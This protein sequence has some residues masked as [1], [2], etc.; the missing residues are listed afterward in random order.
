[1]DRLK[2]TRIVAIATTYETQ[3]TQAEFLALIPDVNLTQSLLGD[4]TPLNLDTLAAEIVQSYGTDFGALVSNTGHYI[5]DDLR[6]ILSIINAF[7][8]DVFGKLTLSEYTD[9][10]YCVLDGNRRSV[11]L[12][13]RLR[14]EQTEYQPVTAMFTEIQQSVSEPIG[15]D[16][17]SQTIEQA[18]LG[19][20]H[21]PVTRK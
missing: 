6:C 3:L 15:S 20:R 13:L 4:N 9:T 14:T 5:S 16:A 12:A 18:Q 17:I 10:G 21:Y 8:F 7:D 11:A 1:M 2:P 19:I